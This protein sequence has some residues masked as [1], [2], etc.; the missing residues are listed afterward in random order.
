MSKGRPKVQPTEIHQASG[1]WCRSGRSLSELRGPLDRVGMGPFWGR[2]THRSAASTGH[3]LTSRVSKV[4]PAAVSRRRAPPRF[5][6]SART[7]RGRAGPTR[8]RT[9]TTSSVTR[10]G[11]AGRLG[12]RESAGAD[13]LV[14]TSMWSTLRCRIGS[15]LGKTERSFWWV[16]VDG[17]ELLHA[18]LAYTACHASGMLDHGVVTDQVVGEGAV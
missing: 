2:A 3:A 9:G 11:G 14:H 4:A 1:T 6:H 7:R 10:S 17:D 15:S 8:E 13:R 12:G 18:V 16:R 5:P